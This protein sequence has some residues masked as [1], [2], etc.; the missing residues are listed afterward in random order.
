MLVGTQYMFS[1]SNIS[2]QMQ[3]KH[4]ICCYANVAGLKESGIYSIRGHCGLFE[5][6]KSSCIVCYLL[7]QSGQN[8][9]ILVAAKRLLTGTCRN[10]KRCCVCCGLGVRRSKYYHE[11][12]SW[13][14]IQPSAECCQKPICSFSLRKCVGESACRRPIGTE[15]TLVESLHHQSYR[16]QLN[17]KPFCG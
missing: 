15:C 3:N 14:E 11:V 17:K 1:I 5:G 4:T 12:H 8:V 10:T 16:R 13:L 2:K 6:T 9:N 7:R